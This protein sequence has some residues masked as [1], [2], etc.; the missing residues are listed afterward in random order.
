M[1]RVLRAAVVGVGA[2]GQHH[3][4]IYAARGDVELVAVVDT[5]RGRAEAVAAR[6][7]TRP[8]TYVGSLLGEVDV[9]SVAVPTI[10]HHD[11]ALRLLA[12]GVHVLVEKPIGGSLDEATAMIEAAR[13]AG[14]VLHVG[15]T[16]RFNPAVQAA[17]SLVKDPRFL[18]CQRLG[19]FARRSL[20]VDVVLD[21][22][23]HDIDVVL[24]L[25]GQPVERIDAVGVNALTD[26]VDIA[27]ARLRFVNGAAANLTASRIS[28]GKTRKLRIFQPASYLSIDYAS[29]QVQHYCLE[30]PGGAAPRI[31]GS[32]LSVDEA[33][34]LAREIDAFL[35]AAAG[36]ADEGVSGEQARAA[37]HV[38]LQVIAE[39]GPP[40]PRR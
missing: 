13:N 35:R 28:M 8:L 16:E 2:L 29:R 14:R 22:M 37:L 40:T 17:R 25:V 4:R 10:A 33:E 24:S 5:D 21:L 3:A 11:V 9:A 1:T 23:I 27:N 19:T 32:E 6:H 20:D 30:R 34:P 38:A 39:I 26:K 18:E 7:A 36:G 31:V 15:H 12:S